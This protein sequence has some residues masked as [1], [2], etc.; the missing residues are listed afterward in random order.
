MRSLACASNGA[1]GGGAEA[2]DPDRC[3]P[4]GLRLVERHGR[5]EPPGAPWVVVWMV[6]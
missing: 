4:A 6:P 3:C 5:R 2:D 1:R